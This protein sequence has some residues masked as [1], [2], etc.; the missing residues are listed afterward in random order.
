M[1]IKSLIQD[2]WASKAKIQAYIYLIEA[3]ILMKF[4]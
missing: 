1:N 2:E 4:A 3:V